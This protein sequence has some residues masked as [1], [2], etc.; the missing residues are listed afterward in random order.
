MR[1]SIWRSPSAPRRLSG[2]GFIQHSS[3]RGA[4]SLDPALK[5][6]DDWGLGPDAVPRITTP[7]TCATDG[8]YKLM[9]L[10]GYL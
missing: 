10:L 6:I 7:L 5:A 2:L 9:R 4:L 3:Q 8:R 1:G